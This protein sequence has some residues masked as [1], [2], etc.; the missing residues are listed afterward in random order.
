MKQCAET[1]EQV[2]LHMDQLAF[3]RAL[4]SIWDLVGALNKYLDESAPW[5]VAKKA[6]GRAELEGILSRSL[7]VLRVVT[8]LLYPFC[9]S[10]AQRMWEM[11]GLPGKVEEQRIEEAQSWGA[12]PEGLQVAKPIPLF[13]RIES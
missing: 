4:G 8:V 11:L 7:T 12:L 10:T 2:A 9:P 6:D 1:F 5:S 3:H 13:P